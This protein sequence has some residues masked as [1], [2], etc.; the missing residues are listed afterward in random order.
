MILFQRGVP[1]PLGSLGRSFFIKSSLLSF[2]KFCLKNLGISFRVFSSFSS[3]SSGFDSK[4]FP[5][6]YIFSHQYPLP[7]VF[8]LAQHS[9]GGPGKAFGKP[10]GS[11]RLSE[12]LKINADHSALKNLSFVPFPILL[13]NS[14]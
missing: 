13:V 10:S 14:Y 2:S 7:V 6:L 11:S 1:R 8:A 12:L 9:R 3:L 4:S 5:S